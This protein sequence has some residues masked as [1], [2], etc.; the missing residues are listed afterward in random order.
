MQQMG[1]A[2]PRQD[3]QAVFQGDDPPSES[4]PAQTLT[5]SSMPLR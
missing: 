2:T 5:L 3:C 4:R 1:H